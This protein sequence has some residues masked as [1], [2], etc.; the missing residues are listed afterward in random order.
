MKITGRKRNG[1]EERAAKYTDRLCNKIILY[2]ALKKETLIFEV[3]KVDGRF[4][5][6]RKK[7]GE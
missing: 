2:L 6:C 1:G 3:A 5:I 7:N 4:E